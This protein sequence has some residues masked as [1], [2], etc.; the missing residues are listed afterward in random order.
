MVFEN[1]RNKPQPPEEEEKP[2]EPLPEYAPPEKEQFVSE[3][4]P[5]Q[6]GEIPADFWQRPRTLRLQR[7]ETS[8]KVETTYWRDGR[9]I[10][11]EY[12]KICR[13]L[14]DVR[15]NKAIEMDPLLLDV[16]RGIQGYY[17]AWQ[18]LKPIIITSGYR[19]PETNSKLSKEGAVKDSMHIH[20]KAVDCFMYGIAPSNIANLALN[21]RTG[22]VGFYP[23]RNFVHVDTGRLRYWRG[24]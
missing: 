17:E 7:Y 18:W 19:T 23:A 1:K 14:R 13:L 5:L 15:A 20:G 8:E 4:R 9:L 6:L 16:L 2:Y 10:R 3:S 24:K 11:D 22:G 12:H 21:M